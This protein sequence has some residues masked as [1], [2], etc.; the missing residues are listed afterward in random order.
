MALDDDGEG[1]MTRAGR[2][3]AYVVDDGA[4]ATRDVG[5]QMREDAVHIRAR[6]TARAEQSGDEL[7]VEHLSEP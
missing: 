1:E 4:R 6:R 7:W 3:G 2:L 5:V